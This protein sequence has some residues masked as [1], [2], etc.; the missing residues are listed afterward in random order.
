MKMSFDN[1]IRY[2]VNDKKFVEQ[3]ISNPGNF[4]NIINRLYRVYRAYDWIE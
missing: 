1:F 4:P 3:I 2:W